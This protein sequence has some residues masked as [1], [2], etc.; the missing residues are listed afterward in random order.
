MNGS[1]GIRIRSFHLT[2]LPTSQKA[3]TGNSLRVGVVAKCGFAELLATGRNLYGKS[4]NGCG[5][6]VVVSR[7]TAESA[8]QSMF[9]VKLQAGPGATRH[10]LPGRKR[11]EQAAENHLEGNRGDE[12]AGQAGEDVDAG[13]SEPLQTS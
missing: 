11:G 1:E 8:G 2:I 4:Q 10:L 13:C 9:R 7:Q 3:V 6:A 5:Q 12:D